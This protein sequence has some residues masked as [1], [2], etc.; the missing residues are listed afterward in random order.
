VEIGVALVAT[1]VVLMAVVGA[2]RW[3]RGQPLALGVLDEP[4][5]R[6]IRVAGTVLRGWVLDPFGVEEVELRLGAVRRPVPFGNVVKKGLEPLYPSYPD[7]AR[8]GFVVELGAAELSGAF[9]EGQGE[10]A[11]AVRSRTGAVTQVE[12]RRLRLTP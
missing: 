10:L 11:I 5:G 6:E 1:I 12:R 2:I 9:P 3:A 4:A 7:A 8:A